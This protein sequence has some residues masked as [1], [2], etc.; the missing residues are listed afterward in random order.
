[1]EKQTDKQLDKIKVPFINY[2]LKDWIKDSDVDGREILFQFTDSDISILH[3]C[4]NQIV[5]ESQKGMIK[6]E[7]VN[8]IIDKIIKEEIEYE[9][10]ED[11]PTKEELSL[12]KILEFK[13]KQSLQRI[14]R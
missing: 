10:F 14:R 13:F 9:D 12:L 3:D 1:M 8:K 6:I 4:I 11:K 5:K 2:T 7:D